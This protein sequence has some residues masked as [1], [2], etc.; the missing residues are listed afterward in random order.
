M[1]N[2]HIG[3]EVR[4]L[5]NLIMR[6][7]EKDINGDSLESITGNNGWILGYLHA[8]SDKDIY[9][10]DIEHTFEVTRSTASRVIKL[11]EEKGFIKRESVKNDARLKKLTITNKGLEICTTLKKYSLEVNTQLVN[12]FTE[13]EINNLEDYIKRMKNNMK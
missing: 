7:I 2:R 8:N 5:N 10:K 12:G 1:K 11:M 13:E 4:A 9:Q 6:N 3:R